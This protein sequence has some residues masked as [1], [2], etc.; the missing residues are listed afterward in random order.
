VREAGVDD[1]RQAAYQRKL[2]ALLAG[3]EAEA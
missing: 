3:R 2:S 1:A